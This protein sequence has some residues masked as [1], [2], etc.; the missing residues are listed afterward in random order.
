M[1]KKTWAVLAVIA[2]S[3]LGMKGLAQTSRHVA[4]HAGHMLDVKTGKMLTDQTLIIEDGKIIS[5]G[6]SG[7]A[8]VPADAVRIE[9]PSECHTVMVTKDGAL[10]G[11]GGKMFKSIDAAVK[12]IQAAASLASVE[13]Q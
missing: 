10:L 6:A 13:I 12:T 9:L 4:V 1:T 7:E 3:C 2:F 11:L 8:K 5:S